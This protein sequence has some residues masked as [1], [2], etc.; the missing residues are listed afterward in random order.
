[1]CVGG[2]LFCGGCGEGGKNKKRAK[3]RKIFGSSK[4]INL[5]FPS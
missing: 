3:T 5:V 4:K 2:V 1:M